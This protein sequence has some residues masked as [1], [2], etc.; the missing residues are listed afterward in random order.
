[1]SYTCPICEKDLS[2][3]ISWNNLG[4]DKILFCSNCSVGLQLHYD[5]M[6]DGE[7]EH[8][9]WNFEIAKRGD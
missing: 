5:E 3:L 6:W 1:M 2:S 7:D 9:Y 4:S 8:Q